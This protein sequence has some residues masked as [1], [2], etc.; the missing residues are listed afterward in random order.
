MS[1][2]Y[3]SAMRAWSLELS[4]SLPLSS[5]AFPGAPGRLREGA[6]ETCKNSMLVGLCF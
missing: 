4:H 3:Y 5:G 2:S 1:L 6:A